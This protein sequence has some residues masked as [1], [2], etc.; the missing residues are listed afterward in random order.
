MFITGLV[1]AAGGSQRMGRPKQLLA[2]RGT[3]LLD[4]T[5][6]MARR[7]A[8]DQLLVT[9][10]GAADEVTA[11]VD[12]TG[13][14]VVENERYGSGCSSSISAA[15][16]LVDPRADGLIL[17]LGDQPGVTVQ[18]V[19][20]LVG[21]ARNSPIGVCGYADG[22]GH[23]LWFRRDS[24]PDLLAL[25][26]DKAVWRLLESG[27]HEVTRVETPGAVPPDVDT[28]DDYL[29]LLAHDAGCRTMPGCPEMKA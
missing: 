1:L 26:G 8:F 22:L 23:P 21:G 24:F 3:T 11:V 28:E 12:L 5:L 9:V 18:N 17:L 19:R 20:G 15:V 25:H 10:G 27:I 14:T 4:V 16:K 29:E 2:F 6:Q 13:I 7:C